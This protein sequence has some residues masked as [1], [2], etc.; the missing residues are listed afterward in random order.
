MIPRYIEFQGRAIEFESR[1]RQKAKGACNAGLIPD[2]PGNG[3]EMKVEQ[4]HGKGPDVWVESG[5]LCTWE[6]QELIKE[7]V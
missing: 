7:S 1:A 3:N 4:R 2:P 6:T 5:Q